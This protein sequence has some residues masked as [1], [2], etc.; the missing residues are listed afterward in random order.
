MKRSLQGVCRQ[1]CHQHITVNYRTPQGGGCVTRWLKFIGR[2]LKKKGGF[3]KSK[4]PKTESEKTSSLGHQSKW[5]KTVGTT[6][7]IRGKIINYKCIRNEI[8]Q[9]IYCSMYY[10][11]DYVLK[12]TNIPLHGQVTYFMHLAFFGWSGWR[13]QSELSS[14]LSWEHK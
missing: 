2:N 14:G 10:I 4:W 13:N 12:Y 5:A 7:E 6:M 8:E 3:S 9:Y 11:E 1:H